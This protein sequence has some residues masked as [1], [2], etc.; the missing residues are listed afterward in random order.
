MISPGR[1]IAL[2]HRGAI[3]I[4]PGVDQAWHLYLMIT[5]VKSQPSSTVD[6]SKGRKVKEHY[7]SPGYGCL[8]SRR[9]RTTMHK[10][11]PNLQENR[12]WS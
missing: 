10:T 4:Y 1:G 6:K 7:L 11:E 3:Y 12:I 2:V 5:I 8:L 9:P